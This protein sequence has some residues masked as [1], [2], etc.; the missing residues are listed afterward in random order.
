MKP[1]DDLHPCPVRGTLDQ[2]GDK[3]SV[4]VILQLSKQ[5]TLRFSD[6]KR[7]I[8]RISQRML[9]QTLRDLERNG[10][11]T[12]TMYPTIPP[13]VEYA[14][15][16]LGSSLVPPISSL[17]AWAEEHRSEI[18]AARRQFDGR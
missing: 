1:S 4:L 6:L 2:V 8:D 10:V 11:I 16:P 5:G 17:V 13:R 7:R 18:I 9:T 14:L 12:R 15:T 3:W